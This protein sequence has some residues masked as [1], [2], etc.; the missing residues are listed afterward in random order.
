[1]KAFFYLLTTLVLISGQASTSASSEVK[2]IASDKSLGDQ[3][4]AA[5]AVSGNTAIVDSPFNDE[6]GVDAGAAYIFVQNGFGW[7]QQAKLIPSDAAAGDR[8]GGSVAIDENTAVVGAAF[9]AD[10]GSQSGSAY[11]FI[12]VGTLWIQQANCS[13]PTSPPATT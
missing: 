4:G 9:N 3:F 2:L 6:A 11:V 13:P 8:F 12:R 1:M 7:V 5:V 10:A